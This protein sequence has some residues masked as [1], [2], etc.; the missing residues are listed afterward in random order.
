ME[1]QKIFTV[2]ELKECIGEA[3]DNW[4][5][6][7]CSRYCEEQKI[8][9]QRAYEDPE[10]LCDDGIYTVGRGYRDIWEALKEYA[11]STGANIAALR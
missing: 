9:L 6:T 8:A 10:T 5:F 1:K 3:L 7:A 4:D 2:A 11:E